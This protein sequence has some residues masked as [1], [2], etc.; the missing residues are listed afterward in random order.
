MNDLLTQYDYI[1]FPVSL[2]SFNGYVP[3]NNPM[4]IKVHSK[5]PRGTL[6]DGVTIYVGQ[7]VIPGEGYCKS[8]DAYFVLRG[9]YDNPYTGKPVSYVR[10]R[11]IMRMY[12]R[13][14][15]DQ[16]NP[17]YYWEFCFNGNC[18]LDQFDKVNKIKQ[19]LIEYAENFK[20]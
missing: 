14:S 11:L 13:Q 9:E 12:R 8:F 7:R 6:S 16:Q 15:D 1:D 3:V 18:S 5:T 2:V 4:F 17:H 19:F 10:D 20:I